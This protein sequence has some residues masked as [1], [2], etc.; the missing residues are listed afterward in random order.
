M[1]RAPVLSPCA[2]R[3]GTQAPDSLKTHWPLALV[4][5][6][7]PTAL[8]EM[9]RTPGVAGAS[10]VTKKPKPPPGVLPEL[11]LPQMPDPS[12]SPARACAGM[13]LALPVCSPEFGEVRFKPLSLPIN[14]L[15]LLEL[16]LGL[17]VVGP[18]AACKCRCRFKQHW[19]AQCQHPRTHC[20]P[21]PVPQ[22]REHTEEM[23]SPELP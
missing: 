3:R 6:H 23:V 15:P 10:K 18:H 14:S 20:V 7:C 17:A 22:L 11:Q 19:C 1:P 13:S 21:S 4:L 12:P 9:A 5:T 8:N 16:V 2:A